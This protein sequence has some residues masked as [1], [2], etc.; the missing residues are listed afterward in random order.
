MNSRSFQRSNNSTLVFKFVD[1]ADKD[2]A[3]DKGLKDGE[4]PNTHLPPQLSQGLEHM[5]LNEKMI[6]IVADKEA[7]GRV[8]DGDLEPLKEPSE[9]ST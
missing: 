5:K 9:T 2:E 4:T 1:Y 7:F 6:N 3:I 8:I